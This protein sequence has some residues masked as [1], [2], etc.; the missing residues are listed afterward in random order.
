[1]IRTGTLLDNRYEILGK[2][3]SGGKFNGV[4]GRTGIFRSKERKLVGNKG[5]NNRA[6][7]NRP[8]VQNISA[9]AQKDAFG[10][11]FLSQQKHLPSEN[12]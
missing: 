10:V 7:E 12:H 9:K 8:F 3:G 4:N 1:M 2:I 5:E 6:D 11:L